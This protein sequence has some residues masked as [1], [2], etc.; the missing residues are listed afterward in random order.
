MDNQ[1]SQ[2]FKPK[3]DY[4]VDNPKSD[5]LQADEQSSAGGLGGI[6]DKL[7]SVAGGRTGGTEDNQSY[8][9]KGKV[10]R[11]SFQPLRMLTIFRFTGISF[12][13]ESITGKS[14]QSTETSEQGDTSH[15][16]AIDAAHPE[17]ISEFLRDQNGS[18]TK[19]ESG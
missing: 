11:V 6:G 5:S 4:T 19:N 8:L 7:S 1:Q 14:G 12:L 3:T 15:H 2:S 16:A 17:Q 18:M 13:Q 9:D 10:Y